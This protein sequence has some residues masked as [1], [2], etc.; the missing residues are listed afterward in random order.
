MP[1]SYGSMLH[2]SPTNSHLIAAQEPYQKA[3]V[4]RQNT[5]DFPEEKKSGEWA[6]RQ[7]KST[8]KDQWKQAEEQE[9][10]WLSGI[11]LQPRGSRQG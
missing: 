6:S 3:N 5:E 8:Q 9:R 7:K 1:L 10:R 4:L 11:K 2:I